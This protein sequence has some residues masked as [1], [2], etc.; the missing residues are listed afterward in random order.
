M[1]WATPCAIR[2][3]IARVL[4]V[5]APASTRSGPRSDS[6]TWRCSG[7]SA[8]SRSG[9]AIRGTTPARRWLDQADGH[10]LDAGG[11]SPDE[12]H[13]HDVQH[14]VVRLLP[15]AEEPARP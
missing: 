2:W 3:V 11:D 12:H 4:P 7:S 5:P 9:A 15:P 10:T 1:P 13:L 6:A 14:P 8:E